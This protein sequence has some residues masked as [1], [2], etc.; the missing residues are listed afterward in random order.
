MIWQSP[1]LI[2]PQSTTAGTIGTNPIINQS[3]IIITSLKN[4]IV[5]A[6]S[7]PTPRVSIGSILSYSIIYSNYC[8]TIR[9][10]FNLYTKSNS[11]GVP[12]KYKCI[13]SYF[14]SVCFLGGKYDR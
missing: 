3:I 14:A 1:N 4:H 5:L 9:N 13:V 12:E 10:I 7:Q 8:N 6:H 2:I 11:Q